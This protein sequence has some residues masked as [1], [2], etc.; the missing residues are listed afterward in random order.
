MANIFVV[1]SLCSLY[2]NIGNQIKP[3]WKMLMKIAS[4]DSNFKTLRD[5]HRV[6]SVKGRVTSGL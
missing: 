1:Q 6:G 4:G 5:T 3:Q 2:A